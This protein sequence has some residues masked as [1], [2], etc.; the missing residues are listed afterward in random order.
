[1]V[2]IER[3]RRALESAGSVLGPTAPVLG[4]PAA[5]EYAGK[6]VAEDWKQDL[7]QFILSLSLSL[8][9]IHIDP[10][11]NLRRRSQ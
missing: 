5:G 9:Q 6:A 11:F 3:S 2:K 10:K 4:T 8:V 1:M 7:E